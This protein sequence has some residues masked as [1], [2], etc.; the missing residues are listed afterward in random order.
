LTDSAQRSTQQDSMQPAL[1]LLTKGWAGFLAGVGLEKLVDVLPAWLRQQRWFGA[2]SRDIAAIRIVF[3]AEIGGEVRGILSTI[4]IPHASTLGDLLLLVAIAYKD[5]AEANRTGGH[6]VEDLYQIPLAF[7]SG[8]GAAALAPENVVLLLATPTGP[9]VLH[10]AAQRSEFR[11]AMLHLITSERSL[12]VYTLRAA[13]HQVAQT[14]VAAHE[15]TPVHTL[16]DSDP[17]IETV[18]LHIQQSHRIEPAQAAPEFAGYMPGDTH[19]PPSQI[20]LSRQTPDQLLGAATIRGVRTE[21]LTDISATQWASRVGATEQSN[22]NFLYGD[23]LLLKLFR[24]LQPGENPDVEI[25]RFLTEQAHFKPIAPLLGQIQLNGTETCTLAMLQPLVRNEGDA[26]QWTLNHLAACLEQCTAQD[27]STPD[28]S[29]SVSADFLRAAALLGQRTAEMHAA[30]ATPAGDPSFTPEPLTPA[31]LECDV[32]RIVDQLHRSLDAL[33]AKLPTLPDDLAVD[34]RTLLSRRAALEQQASS[35]VR[36]PGGG[37]RTRIHG[38][39]HLGQ[40]LRTQDDFVLLDFEGE[41]ARTLAERRMKQCPLKD[42]AGMLRSFAYASATALNSAVNLHA[43]DA[44]RLAACAEAW[45]AGVS[46]IYI[47]RYKSTLYRSPGLLPD[48]ETSDSLLHAYLL[49]K[50]LYELLYELNNRPAWVGIPLH[51][52]LALQY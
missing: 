14:I 15:D 31:D 43:A 10:D 9:A 39:F 12:A 38:D 45:C 27:I 33:Q 7:A 40:V 26:W 35:L 25:G 21:A 23:A 36:R 13:V 46:E 28:A 24:R 6:E 37:M 20:L 19:P 44:D 18:D 8:A 29:S 5:E 4:D 42:V 2:K 52:I 51:G 3:W 22:T 1:D 30:L 34:A 49:E 47:E 11:Q 32:A 48:A 41:P 16:D 50:A 17:D